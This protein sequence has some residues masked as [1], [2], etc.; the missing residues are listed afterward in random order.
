MVDVLLLTSLVRVIPGDTK[1]VF[2][3]VEDLGVAQ[4]ASKNKA[5]FD[6]SD[7]E[8]RTVGFSSDDGFAGRMELYVIVG[9]PTS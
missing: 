9:A 2:A 5:T 8:P 6:A 1:T 3:T 4:A 7:T